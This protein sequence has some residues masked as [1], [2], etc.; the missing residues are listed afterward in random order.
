MRPNLGSGTASIPENGRL[1][2]KTYVNS[3]TRRSGIFTVQCACRHPKLLRVQSSLVL[4]VCIP[5]FSF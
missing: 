3:K 1:C 4:K 5:H 2:R